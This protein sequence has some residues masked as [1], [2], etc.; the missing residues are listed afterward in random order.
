MVLSGDG[1]LEIFDGVT[2]FIIGLCFEHNPIS[3]LLL[4]SHPGWGSMIPAGTAGAADSTYSYRRMSHSPSPFLRAAAPLVPV[5]LTA[6]RVLEGAD[7]S[8]AALTLVTLWLERFA[9][10]RL[11]LP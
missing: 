7:H 8:I 3:R 1:S 4:G 6:V 5:G 10:W 11:H 9:Y 2:S